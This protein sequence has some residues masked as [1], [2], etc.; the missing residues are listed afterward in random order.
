MESPRLPWPRHRARPNVQTVLLLAVELQLLEALLHPLPVGH[1][2]LLG[3]DG[4]L[5]MFLNVA[6]EYPGTDQ[7]DGVGNRMHQC[8]GVVDDEP[9]LFDTPAEPGDKMLT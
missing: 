6:L 4:G 9:P 3:K 5:G 7:I 8:L 1:L 2:V